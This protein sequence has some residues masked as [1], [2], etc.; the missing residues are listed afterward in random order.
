MIYLAAHDSGMIAAAG[1]RRGTEVSR[2]VF[3]VCA[4]DT[5]QTVTHENG[6]EMQ[7]SKHRL[8]LLQLDGATIWLFSSVDSVVTLERS[9]RAI[10]TRVNTP[11]Q[12]GCDLGSHPCI[13]HSVIDNGRQRQ[14]SLVD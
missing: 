13:I 12:N 11:L 5:D 7:R 3:C 14:V 1:E 9:H 6:S 10:V 8:G 2:F 4:D